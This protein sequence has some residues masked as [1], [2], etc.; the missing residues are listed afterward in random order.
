MR[1]R[2][3]KLIKNGHGQKNEEL[4]LKFNNSKAKD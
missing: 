4:N 1:K 3:F 2:Q